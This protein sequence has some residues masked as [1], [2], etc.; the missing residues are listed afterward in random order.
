MRTALTMMLHIFLSCCLLNAVQGSTNPNAGSISGKVVDSAG[1]AIPG[2]RVTIIHHS[3]EN[4]FE[5]VTD[6]S[7]TYQADVLPGNYA[8]RFEGQGFR[9]K[10]IASLHVEMS[11][12]TRIDARLRIDKAVKRELVHDAGADLR[13]GA[14]RRKGDSLN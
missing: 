12:A 6:C 14:I 9:S 7:G 5:T 1:N 3:N 10:S 13:F 8:L 11:Q 4:H 2:A